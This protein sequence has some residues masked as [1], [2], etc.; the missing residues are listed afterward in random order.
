MRREKRL[1]YVLFNQ[2]ALLKSHNAQR[3]MDRGA[4]KTVVGLGSLLSDR[5]CAEF[6]KK[7]TKKQEKIRVQSYLMCGCLSLNLW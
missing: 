7:K 1:Q 4:I 3:L 6:I 5:S 2:R